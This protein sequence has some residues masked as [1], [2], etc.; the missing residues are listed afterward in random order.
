MLAYFVLKKQFFNDFH[1]EITV[2]NK[3]IS[4]VTENSMI[5]FQTF[6]KINEHVN[7]E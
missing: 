3:N 4:V 7:E 6:K 2:L 5:T 1:W